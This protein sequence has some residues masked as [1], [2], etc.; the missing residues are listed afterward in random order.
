[1]RILVVEDEPELRETIAEGLR[2]DGYAVDT[3]AD[4]ANAYELARIEP[5][6]LL[7]LDL[8]L[9]EMNGFEVLR[10]LRCDKPDLKVLILTA[11]SDVDD[12]VEGLDLGANDY[13]TK[14]FAFKELE[15]R[16]RALLRRQFTQQETVLTHGGLALDT[17]TRT[18]SANGQNLALTRKELALLEYFMRN[19]GRVISAEELIEHVWDGSVDSFSNAIRVHITSLRK[20]IRETMDLNPIENRIG[21][22]Y[23]L[24]DG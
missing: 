19:K 5:Y 8:N 18:A 2:M 9:P 20:K 17:K 24:C 12:K 16:I 11:R 3:S 14:P 6:D 22:G 7:L 1:M 10:A 23:I 4:G 13:L 15:A 21:E